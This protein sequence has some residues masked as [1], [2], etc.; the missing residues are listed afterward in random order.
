ML[1]DVATSD[2]LSHV[3]DVVSQNVVHLK[4][5]VQKCLNA[6]GI[7]MTDVE[8]LEEVFNTPV[9]FESAFERLKSVRQRTEYAISNLK[10]VVSYQRILK[11]SYFHFYGVELV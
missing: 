3:K 7:D 11:L 2:L 10:M 4:E 8:G 9:P 1:T 6:E 5:R